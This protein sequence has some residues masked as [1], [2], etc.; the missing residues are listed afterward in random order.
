MKLAVVGS[1]TFNDYKLLKEHLDEIHAVTPITLII[2]GGAKGADSLAEKWAHQNNIETLIFKPEWDRYGKQAGYLRNKDIIL[3]SD[4]VLAMW[5]GVSKGT[6]HSIN[7]AD[8][9]QIP[10]TVVNFKN[11]I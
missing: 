5:D 7:I 2:S 3:N 6:L 9:H 1:R 10:Y 4:R 8:H 11:D